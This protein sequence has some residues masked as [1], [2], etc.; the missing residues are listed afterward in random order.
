MKIQGLSDKAINR[1]KQNFKQPKKAQ[2]A[3]VGKESY[4]I[5]IAGQTAF[6]EAVVNEVETMLELDPEL[7]KEVANDVLY[8]LGGADLND[9]VNIMVEG[10]TRKFSEKG[11]EIIDE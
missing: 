9:L 4:D 7:A 8:Y 5:V 3:D 2:D 6:V 1:I 10:I 11:I